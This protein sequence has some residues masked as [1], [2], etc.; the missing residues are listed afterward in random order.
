MLFTSSVSLLIFILLARSVTEGVMFKPP[1]MT[2]H[3]PLLF[4]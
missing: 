1:I 4:F 2:V 3:F